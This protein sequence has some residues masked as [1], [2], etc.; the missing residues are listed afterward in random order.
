MVRKI[1]VDVT[2][3]EGFVNSGDMQKAVDALQKLAREAISAP[4]GGNL[5][6]LMILDQDGQYTMQVQGA[7]SGENQKIRDAI[8]QILDAQ[9]I[10]LPDG[11]H[12]V[13]VRRDRPKG[14]ISLPVASM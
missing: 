13:P 3:V 1:E 12:A 5:F 2:E 4:D 9:A 6:P 8:K 11:I 7:G 10:I 14:S